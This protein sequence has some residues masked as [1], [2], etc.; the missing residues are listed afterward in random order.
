LISF[1]EG[2]KVEMLGEDGN[3]V[4]RPK[5]EWFEFN[6]TFDHGTLTSINR[7]SVS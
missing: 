5:A 1:K 7:L 4:P 6:A 3:P 2:T